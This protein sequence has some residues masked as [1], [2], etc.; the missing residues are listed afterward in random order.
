MIVRVGLDFT[1]LLQRPYYRGID[2]CPVIHSTIIPFRRP[3]HTIGEK[4]RSFV[5]EES[6]TETERERVSSLD[7]P[8][9]AD[10]ERQTDGRNE[11]DYV[12]NVRR[13]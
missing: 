5:A 7:F 11:C 1:E 13:R 10:T 2:W 8:S 12:V 6:W 4:R 9:Y 3:A